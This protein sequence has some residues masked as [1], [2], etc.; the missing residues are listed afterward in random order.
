MIELN[1]TFSP[2]AQIGV[3][4][5]EQL[6]ACSLQAG[7]LRAGHLHRLILEWSDN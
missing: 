2:F 1:Q 7:R 5:N 4:S 6:L 3:V